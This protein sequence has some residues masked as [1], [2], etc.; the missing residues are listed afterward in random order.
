MS[1]FDCLRINP[2]GAILQTQNPALKWFVARDLMD[3]PESP[4]QLIWELHEPQKILRRQLPDGSWRYPGKG[5]NNR[6]GTNN[7][8]LETFRNLRI[9]VEKYAFSLEH[10]QMRM[11]FDYIYSCQT[12]EGD[13][14]GILSNQ[15]MPYYMGAILALASKAGDM[16][17]AHVRKGLDWLLGMRQDDGAWF[18]PLQAYKITYLNQVAHNDPIPPDR[19]LPSSHLATGMV[20]RAFGEHDQYRKRMEVRAAGQVLKSR[21]LKPDAYPDHQDIKYWTKFQFPF[22]WTDLL[23]AMDLLQKIGFGRT[24]KDIQR[25]MEWFIQNQGPDGLWKATYE[26]RAEMDLWVSLAVCRVL[27]RFQEDDAAQ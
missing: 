25:G 6:L 3:E 17:N 18:I 2:L 11:A 23:S 13:I 8:L 4:K 9:L 10:A 26:K 19:K 16:Q 21:F 15:Y 20:L 7:F 12:P 1:W 14:R 27:K 22:W 5:S 24:D